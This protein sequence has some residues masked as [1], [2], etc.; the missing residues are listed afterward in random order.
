MGTRH[1]CAFLA[2]LGQFRPLIL[3]LQTKRLLG[4]F[5]IFY[6]GFSLELGKAKGE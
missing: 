3:L 6:G 4:Q 1:F 2:F 5:P